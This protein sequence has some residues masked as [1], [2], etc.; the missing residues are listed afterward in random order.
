MPCCAG[1]SYGEA[2]TQGDVIGCAVDMDAGTVAFSRN[3]AYLGC[4]FT[5]IKR[6]LPYFPAASLSYGERQLIFSEAG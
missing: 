4:A 6:H 5:G 1:L 3:G 2:W